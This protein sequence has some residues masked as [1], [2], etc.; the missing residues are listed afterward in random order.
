MLEL[1]HVVYFSDASPGENASTYGHTVVGGQHKHWGTSNALMYTR[2][3]YIEYL[4]VHDRK[5]AAKSTH[6]LPTLLLHDLKHGA[7]QVGER[8][9]FVQTIS[10]HLIRDF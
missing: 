3:S 9:V 8:F 6:P 4:S 7:V 2:D 10:I 1:D 5:C